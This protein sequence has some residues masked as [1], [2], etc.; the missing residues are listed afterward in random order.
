MTK[1]DATMKPRIVLATLAAASALGLVFGSALIAAADD[2]DQSTPV[3]VSLPAGMTSTTTSVMPG[4]TP[5][6]KY[7]VINMLRVRNQ[8]RLQP[9]N[10]LYKD[11]ALR[12]ENGDVYYVDPKVTAALPTALSEGSLGPGEAFV[13]SIAFKVPSTV[14]N[15]ALGYYV[16]Q[17]D[18]NYPSY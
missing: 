15:A 6:T 1:Y 2:S 17:F 13:G 12:V 10:V 18:A 5:Q 8:S 3:Q 4:P 16:T 9:L 7:V 11:F 14:R